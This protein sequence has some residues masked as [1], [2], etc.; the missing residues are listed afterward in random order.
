MYR[1]PPLCGCPEDD[2]PPLEPPPTDP[3]EHAAT[4]T[5]VATAPTIAKVREA[6]NERLI[7]SPFQNWHLLDATSDMDIQTT[8]SPAAAIAR[9]LHIRTDRHCYVSSSRRLKQC[10]AQYIYVRMLSIRSYRS[11][12]WK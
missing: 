5:S 12:A 7:H 10:T 3:E 6:R 1:V 9:A 2:V 11:Y 8:A 4:P